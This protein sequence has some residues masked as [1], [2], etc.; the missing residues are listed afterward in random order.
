MTEHIFTNKGEKIIV[1]SNQFEYLN[2]FTWS[3]NINGY[4]QGRIEKE[5]YLMHRYLMRLQ[6]GDKQQVDHINHNKL[7]NR[8]ENLRVCVPSENMFN[9]KISKFN[10]TGAK[11]VCRV[12]NRYKAQIQINKKQIHLGL[13]DTIKD[14]KRAYDK[15][16]KDK[17]GKFF[18]QE[19]NN[20]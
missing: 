8:I 10:T 3:I 12:G 5:H 7:D 2:K 11:G 1:D 19:N 18:I 15:F 14:A 4:A 9:L 16:A 20:G 13:F 6:K 17:H